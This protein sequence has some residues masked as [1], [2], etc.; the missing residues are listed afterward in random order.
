VNKT[1]L[2]PRV[3]AAA[4]GRA[5]TYTLDFPDVKFHV[6]AL[7]DI[8]ESYP[9]PAS[10]S[11]SKVNQFVHAPTSLDMQHFILIHARVFE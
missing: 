2:K 10:G 4:A 8:G 5:N 3:A 11:R 6:P 7:Y 9:V 1:I